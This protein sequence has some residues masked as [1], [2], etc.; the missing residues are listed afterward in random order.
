M[1]ALSTLQCVDR[2]SNGIAC[3]TCCRP[4]QAGLWLVR[5]LEIFQSFYSDKHYEGPLPAISVVSILLGTAHMCNLLSVKRPIPG[6]VWIS[7]A[8]Y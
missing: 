3:N 8:L 1:L 5:A 2:I 7:Q 4:H 6:S